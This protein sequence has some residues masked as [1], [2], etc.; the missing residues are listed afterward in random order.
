MVLIVF[1]FSACQKAPKEPEMNADQEEALETSSKENN[2][3]EV[4][5]QNQDGVEVGLATLTQQKEGVE[6]KVEASHISAGM[7][8][9]HIHE[10]GMCQPPNFESAG[11]H[12]N[13]D[14]KEHGFKSE[15]G[16]HAGDIENLEVAEDGTVNQTFLNR[17]VTLEKGKQNSLLGDNGA[18][19][20]IHEMEDDDVSQPAGNAGERIVCGVISP[21]QQ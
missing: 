6:I 5:L 11:G 8:G 21:S 17:H 12:F 19:L 20:I 3:I 9:F 1:V 15:H 7:H 18:S 2:V 14:E 10:S 4:A 16:P 13:P